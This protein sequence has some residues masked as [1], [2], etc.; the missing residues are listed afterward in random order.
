M[1]GTVGAILFSTGFPPSKGSGW[2][3]LTG[4]VDPICLQLTFPMYNLGALRMSLEVMGFYIWAVM[5][6]NKYT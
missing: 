5:R 6:L 1:D 2:G 4:M 3:R